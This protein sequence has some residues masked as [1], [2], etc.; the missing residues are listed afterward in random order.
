MSARTWTFNCRPVGAEG[1]LFLDVSATA[2]T[3]Q[4]ALAIVSEKHPD[5]EHFHMDTASLAAARLAESGS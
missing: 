2:G 4:E 5:K 1:V 3:W